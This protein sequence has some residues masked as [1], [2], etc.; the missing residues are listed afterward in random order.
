LTRSRG[1]C[2]G[3]SPRERFIGYNANEAKRA[4]KDDSVT[5]HTPVYE[6]GFNADEIKRL[7]ERNF[8]T[9]PYDYSIAFNASESGRVKE[10]AERKQVFRFPLI[11]MG[12]DREWCE[13]TLDNFLFDATEGRIT[14]GKKSYCVN[15]CP[16]SECNGK[17]RQ[18]GNNTHTD[19]REDW[20]LEPHYGGEAALIEHVALG[21]NTRQPLFTEK[22]VVDVLTESNNTAALDYYHELLS[23]QHWPELVAPRLAG[24]D[25]ELATQQANRLRESKT[26]AVYVVRRI[27]D[28]KAK[29]PYRQNKIIHQGTEDSSL[30]YLHELSD[31]HGKAPTLEQL[32][33]RLW[34]IPRPEPEV[35]FTPGRGGKQKKTII[36]PNPPY[37]EEQF[38]ALPAAPY[39][40]QRISDEAYALK[41]A[42]ITGNIPTVLGETDYGTSTSYR[43]H[44]STRK[45][46]RRSA[47]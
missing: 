44:R 47:A 39:E 5:Q 21:L 20:L 8:G 40:K 16:F 4:E 45:G 6:V 42:S 9:Q 12:L 26:W 33:W 23:G 30:K 46:K 13:K 11:E 28:G 3:D 22:L 34:T 43:I 38:V 7:K 19:L 14:R 15:C 25:R 10:S 36:K 17:K 37:V 41:W 24:L 32:S 18:K 1:T 29:V 27:W 31:R 35:T 2:F